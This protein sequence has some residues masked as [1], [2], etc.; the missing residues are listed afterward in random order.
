QINAGLNHLFGVPDSVWPKIL[1]ITLLTA[2]ATWSIVRGLDKGVKFLSNLNIGMAVGLMLFV[3]FFGD[4]IFLLRQLIESVRICAQSITPHS[5]WN[6][7][8][9]QFTTV[10]WGWQIDCTVL[11]GSWTVSCAPL[12]RVF[13]T[14]F[15]HGRT[16]RFFVIG[17]LLAPAT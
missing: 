3:L 1:I 9:S 4:T 10:G 15:S 2:V 17:V 11:Y 14:Q 16:I 12:M 8:M 6:V 13:L 5:F 7:A